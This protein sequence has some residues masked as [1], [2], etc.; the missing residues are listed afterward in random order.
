MTPLSRR[1]L[2][3]PQSAQPSE[4]PAKGRKAAAMNFLVAK[5]WRCTTKPGGIYF[6]LFEWPASGRFEVSGFKG[7]AK[8]AYILGDPKRQRLTVSQ[9]NSTLSIT[10]PSSAPG[11]LASVV[12]VEVAEDA[13]R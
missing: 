8:R 12:C 5:E 1:G 6:H 2:P 3:A 10:L 9:S 4:V 13:V 7:K 11:E